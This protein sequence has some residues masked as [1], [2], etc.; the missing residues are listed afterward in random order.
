MES[1]VVQGT[2]RSEYAYRSL[3]YRILTREVVDGVVTSEHRLCGLTVK[4]SNNVRLPET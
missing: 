4:R 3:G 2:T 1:A